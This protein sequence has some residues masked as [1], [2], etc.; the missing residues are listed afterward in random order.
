VN[1][2]RYWLYILELA[3]GHLYT[4]YTNNLVRR[5]REHLAGRGARTTRSFPPVRIA[6]CWRI[7]TDA[8]TILRLELMI[9]RLGRSGKMAL[10]GEPARLRPMAREKLRVRGGPYLFDA[11][12]VNAVVQDTTVPSEPDPFADQPLR[13]LP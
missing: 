11:N 13:D 8:G 5:Y 10:L 2:Q 3:N 7:A 12:R 6:G 1:R 9:K 4:G